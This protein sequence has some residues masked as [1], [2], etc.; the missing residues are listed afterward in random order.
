[1]PEANYAVTVPCLIDVGLYHPLWFHSSSPEWTR[2]YFRNVISSAERHSSRIQEASTA[3][4]YHPS[5]CHLFTIPANSRGTRLGENRGNLLQNEAD[6]FGII[7]LASS[8]KVKGML[9]VFLCSLSYPSGLVKKIS[10]VVWFVRNS[11][12][13]HIFPPFK[14]GYGQVNLCST[15]SDIRWSANLSGTKPICVLLSLSSIGVWFV[16]DLCRVTSVSGSVRFG[17]P[18][19]FL[20]RLQNSFLSCLSGADVFRRLMAVFLCHWWSL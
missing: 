11:I 16:F 17:S 7:A 3:L 19:W 18:P 12:L 8:R 9:L 6:S 5:K 1:M 15:L 20:L 10:P 14:C 2:K 4:V 13:L